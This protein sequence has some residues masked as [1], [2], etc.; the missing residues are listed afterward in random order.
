MR[1]LIMKGY[2]VENRGLNSLAIIY[3][4]PTPGVG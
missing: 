2:F 1:A 3:N 4:K